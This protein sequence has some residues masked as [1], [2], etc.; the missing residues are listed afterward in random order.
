[1]GT[2]RKLLCEKNLTKEEVA[3]FRGAIAN[4]TVYDLYY[5]NI[6]LKLQVGV[7]ASDP[8]VDQTLNR[9]PGLYLANHL[10]FHI[11]YLGNE[12][13][14]MYAKGQYDFAGEISKDAEIKVVN[15]TYSV[16]W[17]DFVSKPEYQNEIMRDFWKHN[18][19]GLHDPMSYATAFIILVWL[20]M[21]YEVTVT[22]LT[23]YFT[24]YHSVSIF[25]YVV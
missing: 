8:V 13:K 22:Y 10:D 7:N 3:K 17:E 6:R 25:S 1:M 18:G 9:S 14:H 19:G 12:V 20:F 4:K 16:F 21:L 2:T 5:D 15:F 23:D 24:R 11:L